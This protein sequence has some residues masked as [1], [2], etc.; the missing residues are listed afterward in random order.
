MA[1]INALDALMELKLVM[2]QVFPLHAVLIVM[3]IYIILNFFLIRS[4]LRLDFVM[5]MM[6][7]FLNV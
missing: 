6:A 7:K 1:S 5:I 3:D 4:A 2:G